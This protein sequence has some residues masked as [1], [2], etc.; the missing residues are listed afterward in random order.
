MTMILATLLIVYKKTNK[1]KGY[2]ITKLAFE[3]ELNNEMIKAIVILCG[4]DPN[5]AKHL[6]SQ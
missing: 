2:K 5:K 3:T 6:W 1:M 4:G